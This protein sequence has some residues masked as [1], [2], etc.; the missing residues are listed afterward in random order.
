M[1][2]SE[3]LGKAINSLS[4]IEKDIKSNKKIKNKKL[5]KAIKDLDVLLKI[6][7]NT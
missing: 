1:R 4:S 3:K 2:E 7:K 5:E 6:Y